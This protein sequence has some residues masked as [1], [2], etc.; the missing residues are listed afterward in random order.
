MAST[1][2]RFADFFSS[3][4]A[5]AFPPL[6]HRM[7]RTKSKRAA[8]PLG[9]SVIR[10]TKSRRLLDASALPRIWRRDGWTRRLSLL[11]WLAGGP[12][13]RVAHRLATRG[14]QSRRFEMTNDYWM[15]IKVD[16]NCSTHR[17]PINIL[18]V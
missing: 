10:I 5:D 1:L 11:G 9:A 16:P 12:P 13:Y 6:G 18:G 3:S 4:A 14:E 8:M 2:S 17:D 7:L 15:R